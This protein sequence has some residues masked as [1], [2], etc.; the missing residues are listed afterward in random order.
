MKPVTLHVLYGLKIVRP[1][2]LY[3]TFEEQ[4]KKKSNWFYLFELLVGKAAVVGWQTTFSLYN[5]G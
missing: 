1:E 5:K 3:L 2:R 4:P